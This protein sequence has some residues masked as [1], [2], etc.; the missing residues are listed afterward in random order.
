MQC[1]QRRRVNCLEPAFSPALMA[2]ANIAGLAPP[3]ALPCPAAGPV[4]LL[5]GLN[6]RPSVLVMHFAMVALFG[7]G[8][9]IFPRPTLRGVWLGVLLLYSAACIIL[10]IIWKGEWQ[11]VLRLGCAWP[12]SPCSCMLLKLQE[13]VCKSYSCTLN[14][15]SCCSLCRGHPRRLLPVPRLQAAPQR[16]AAAPPRGGGS[17][18]RGVNGA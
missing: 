15:C 10:P 14:P 11:R 8:R 16:Q 13:S 12:C 7:V 2:E 9:L 1:W 18:Q 3:P 4:S 6:P 5:S 17:T